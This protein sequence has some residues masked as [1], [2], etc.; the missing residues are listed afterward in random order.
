MKASEK[1]KIPLVEVFT[2]DLPPKRIFSNAGYIINLQ[3]STEG[4]GTHF[5]S[6]FFTR[7]KDPIY[8]DSFGQPPPQSVINWIHLML[9]N[10]IIEYN[11]KEIQWIETGY[12]GIYDLFFIDFMAK[13]PYHQSPAILLKKFG[14]L[15][16]NNPKDNLEILKK[17]A[18]YW[19]YVES[20]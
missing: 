17:N 8:F 1:Y 10:K 4:K 7:N 19:K 15:F 9:P 18:P 11:T 2:K 14:N 6:V 13:Q 3:D 5:V 12:C 16:S 20:D